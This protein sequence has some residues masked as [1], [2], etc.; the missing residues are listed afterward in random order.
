MRWKTFLANALRGVNSSIKIA[1]PIPKGSVIRLHMAQ[2]Q[3]VPIIAGHIPAFSGS[4]S[5]EPVKSVQLRA[6]TP[7]ISMDPSRNARISTETDATAMHMRRNIVSFVIRESILRIFDLSKRPLSVRLPDSSPSIIGVAFFGVSR[8]AF[9][10][11]RGS[12]SLI[13]R[14]PDTSSECDYRQS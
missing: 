14:S 6:G 9:S 3:S 8:V 12:V 5:G 2:T 13:R 11:S 10:P 1:V 7:D 4:G